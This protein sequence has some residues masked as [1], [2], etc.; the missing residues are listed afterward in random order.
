MSALK[1]FGP[2]LF[3]VAVALVAWASGLLGNLSPEGIAAREAQI[4]GLAAQHPLQAIAL[5]VL[6]YTLL[7]AA[8]LPV[9]MLLSLLGGYLFGAAPA[10]LALVIA[11]T[12]SS[13]ITYGAARSA[14]GPWVSRRMR[15][16]NRLSAVIENIR[17]EAFFYVLSLRFVPV[18]PFGAIN[19]AAGVAKAPLLPFLSATVLGILPACVIYAGLG[20]GLKSS[21]GE[22]RFDLRAAAMK[23]EL[24]L[25]L[26]GLGVLA[27]AAGW[28]RSRQRASPTT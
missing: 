6:A 22:G 23:P 3:L 15:A 28:F 16:S 27:L 8:C 14:I 11:A 26:A 20:A 5:Y 4:S 21:L 24:F 17:G 13:L 19:A 10:A 2:L 25:P 7:T 1:R 18:A 9:A 12:A